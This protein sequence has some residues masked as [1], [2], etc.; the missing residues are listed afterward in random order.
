M[1]HAIIFTFFTSNDYNSINIKICFFL[2][3]FSLNITINALFFI[4]STI[5]KI[6]ED[7]G[8][9]NFFY[10]LPQIIYSVIISSVINALLSYLS[11]TQK[12]I[13]ELKKMKKKKL[14][15]NFLR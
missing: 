9:F 10:Q 7:E 4:D 14:I 8:D 3:S 12:N 5:H 15:W 11:L 2:F 13:L 6:Y 1:K